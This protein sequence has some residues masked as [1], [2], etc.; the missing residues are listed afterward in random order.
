MPFRLNYQASPPFRELTLIIIDPHFSKNDLHKKMI[1]IA[2]F[3]RFNYASQVSQ[4]RASLYSKLSSILCFGW[5][6]ASRVEAF[7]LCNGFF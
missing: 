6:K 2:A 1:F 3:F 7:C 4:Q 5:G